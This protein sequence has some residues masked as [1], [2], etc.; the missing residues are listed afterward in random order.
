MRVCEQAEAG[1]IVHISRYISRI[2]SICRCVPAV[3][4]AVQ[5]KGCGC[6]LD[7][8]S[9]DP[10]NNLKTEDRN[11]KCRESIE[12]FA[13]RVKDMKPAVVIILK[14]SIVKDILKSIEISDV[15]IDKDHI[16]LLY[17][18]TFGHQRRYVTGLTEVLQKLQLEA[19]L[20]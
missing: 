7:D 10:V 4:P 5:F 19:I 3:V 2:F 15:D 11:T 12:T 6:Y 17:F 9:L 16:Y 1:L 20:S 14:R 13:M 8:L 18:P